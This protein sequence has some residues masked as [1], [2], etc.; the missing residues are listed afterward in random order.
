[1][2]GHFELTFPSSNLTET[3]NGTK[4]PYLLNKYK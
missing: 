2:P 3:C 1:M 4:I